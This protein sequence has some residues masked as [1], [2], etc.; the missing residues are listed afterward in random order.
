MAPQGSQLNGRSLS[1]SI[2]TIFKFLSHV[3]KIS[4]IVTPNRYASNKFK[5]K[6]NLCSFIFLFYLYFLN[7]KKPDGK[8]CRPFFLCPAGFG[9]FEV[10][11]LFQNHILDL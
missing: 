8:F 6:C 4:L 1:D 2:F 10:S 9:V 3:K 11:G 7:I 5:R